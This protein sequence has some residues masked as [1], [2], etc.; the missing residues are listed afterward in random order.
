MGFNFPAVLSCRSAPRPAS[1]CSRARRWHTRR[2]AQT[3]CVCVPLQVCCDC[4]LC[5]HMVALGGCEPSCDI[6]QPQAQACGTGIHTTAGSSNV[7]CEV[8]KIEEAKAC[9]CSTAHTS[10]HILSQVLFMRVHVC[11]CVHAHRRSWRLG[12][13]M[14]CPTCLLPRCQQSGPTPPPLLQHEAAL[15]VERNK[16]SPGKH[17]MLVAG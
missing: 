12:C 4:C 9:S 3:R 8:L 13:V 16:G 14:C 10:G 17:D 2:Q 1:S 7:S 5:C 11:I 6:F 15:S